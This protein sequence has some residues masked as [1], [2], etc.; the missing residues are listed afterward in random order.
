MIKLIALDLDGTICDLVDAHFHSLNQAIEEIAGPEYTISQTEQDQYFNGLSTKTKL[1]KL[2]NEK[3]LPFDLISKINIKKQEYTIKYIRDNI[4]P[5]S[6]LYND[7]ARL[8]SEGYLLYCASNALFATVE[9]GL[10]ALG[11][12]DL[13]DNII[14]N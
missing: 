10:N 6:Q 12:I 7:L 5:N 13:F 1:I 3:S 14:G 11:I 9:A 4:K 2:C 8:K